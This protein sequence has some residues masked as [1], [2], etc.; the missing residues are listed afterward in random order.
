M[1][2]PKLF[3]T[4][5]Q[6]LWTLFLLFSLFLMRME[7]EYRTYREFISKPFY[8][9]YA[10][11]VNAYMK[12]KGKHTYQVVK[13][14][15]DEGRIFYTT[16]H[17][18]KLLSQRRLRLQIFPD[19]KI[20]FTDFLG[21]FYVKSRI[22]AVEVPP[23]TLKTFLVE[24]VRTQHAEALLASFYNAIFFS[25]PVPK[26]LRKKISLLG[27]SHLIALSGF[28]LGILWTI[29]YGGLLL[30]YRFF[31]QRYFPYR[32]ALLDVGMAAILLLGVYV[33]FVGAPPSLLRA[34]VM[35]VAGWMML[36]LGIELLS[37]GFLATI[38]FL[39]LFLSPALSVSLGF[40][41]SLSGV[42]YIFLLLQYAR[43]SPKLTV[44]LLLIPVGIF[45]LML[46]VTHLFFGTTSP[47]QLLSPLLSLLFI[48]FYPMAML[49]HLIGSGAWFDSSLIWLFSLPDGGEE[50]MLSWPMAAG[51]LLLS[52]AAV[53]SRKAYLLL[54]IAA[55]GYALYLFL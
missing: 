2:K 10:T 25:T 31:Q 42:F 32:Y 49:V 37:F 38:A 14:R 20:T 3:E 11:V 54:W 4:K 39:L 35:I 5:Q 15:S 6:F 28:H 53:L 22:R 51:Y 13:L 52:L 45:L 21:G 46:P 19:K 26:K 18:K 29:V 16:T 47:C 23:H 30:C 24:K 27:V 12:Q 9:T 1:E 55:V 17:Q 36:L 43:H 44:T 50:Q 48:P 34:Y 7:G 8:F 33:W 41:L 40:W